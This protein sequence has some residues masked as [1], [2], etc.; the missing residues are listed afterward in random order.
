MLCT[1][2]PA[3]PGSPGHQWPTYFKGEDTEIQRECLAQGWPCDWNK[4][5]NHFP[6]ES[7]CFRGSCFLPKRKS[8]GRQA[9]E[10][11]CQAQGNNCWFLSLPSQFGTQASSACALRHTSGRGSVLHTSPGLTRTLDSGLSQL[12]SS[13]L[14][15][16]TVNSRNRGTASVCAIC[17]SVQYRTGNL[18]SR[19]SINMY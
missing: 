7:G 16:Q 19:Q 10:V 8:K 5:G 11:L 13:Y 4:A 2:A 12:T 3:N 18:V 14:S 17:P 6:V 15:Y 1:L 9:K